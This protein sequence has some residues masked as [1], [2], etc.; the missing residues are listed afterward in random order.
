MTVPVDERTALIHI[1]E[2][3]KQIVTELQ[4]LR[5]GLSKAIVSTGQSPSR[6]SGYR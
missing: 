1:N 3:L 6:G 4:H 5:A 2:T